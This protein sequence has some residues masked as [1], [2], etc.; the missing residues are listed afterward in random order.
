MVEERMAR[1][2]RIT[3]GDGWSGGGGGL[4]GGRW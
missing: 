4:S 2:A 3:G 1:K